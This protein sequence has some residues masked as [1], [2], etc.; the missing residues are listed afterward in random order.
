VWLVVEALAARLGARG[1]PNQSSASAS[2]PFSANRSAS[3][4]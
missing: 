1:A 3:S 2:T 4:S